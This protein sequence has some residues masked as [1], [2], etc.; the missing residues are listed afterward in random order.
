MSKHASEGL[1]LPEKIVKA[2]RYSTCIKAVHHKIS[3]H[4]PFMSRNIS[5][6]WKLIQT[7]VFLYFNKFFRIVF[8]IRVGRRRGG[9]VE[10]KITLCLWCELYYCM[11]R[12]VTWIKALVYVQISQLLWIKVQRS[13]AI[14]SIP[15]W[16][17]TRS[18]KLDICSSYNFKQF[19]LF[20]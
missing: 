15:V 8:K 6:G 19:V 3:S 5:P 20:H 14:A 13:I 17:A 11:R 4:N 9:K 12:A 1:W 10:I 18:R 7:N 16:W 2:L